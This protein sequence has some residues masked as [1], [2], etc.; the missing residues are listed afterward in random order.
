MPPVE[1]WTCKLVRNAFGTTYYGDVAPSR[2]EA[3]RS[4][5]QR[6]VRS[7]SFSSNC[8]PNESVTTCSNQ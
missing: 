8:S 5:Y 2:G 1:R 6:C 7:E 3:E 4:V